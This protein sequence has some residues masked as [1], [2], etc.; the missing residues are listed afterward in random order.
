MPKFY[1][2]FNELHRATLFALLSGLDVGEWGIDSHGLSS[3]IN[4]DDAV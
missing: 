1:P 2:S 4:E 3:E